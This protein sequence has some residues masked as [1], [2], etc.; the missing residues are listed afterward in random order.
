L[1]RFF[2]QSEFRVSPQATAVFQNAGVAVPGWLT[3]R[4]NCR[5]TKAPAVQATRHAHYVTIPEQLVAHVTGDFRKLTSSSSDGWD[6]SN[7]LNWI[8]QETCLASQI[9]G[10]QTLGSAGEK[11]LRKVK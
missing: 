11:C 3:E 4:T 10:G 6:Q 8:R 9:M 1:G 5:S 2:T 7:K